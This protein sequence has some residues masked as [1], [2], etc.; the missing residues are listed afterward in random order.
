LHTGSEQVFLL[1][2]KSFLAY[3]ATLLHTF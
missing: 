1:Q 3:G 2:W